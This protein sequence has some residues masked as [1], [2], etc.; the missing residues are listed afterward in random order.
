M[1]INVVCERCERTYRVPDEKAGQ[2][3][4]CVCGA[5]IRVPGGADTEHPDSPD[6]LQAMCA[7]TS[8]RYTTTD[9]GACVFQFHSNAKPEA[10]LVVAKMSSN[11]KWVAVYGTVLEDRGDPSPDLLR[12]LMELNE[13]LWQGKFS[14]S[15]AGNVDFQFECPTATLDVQELRECIATC[16]KVI[17]ER[18]EELSGLG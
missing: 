5:L 17:D 9:T 11:G 16:A 4:R 8:F 10:V 1:E 6:Q 13:E 2:T 12:R 15:N 14:L 3:G 18:Y 7:E